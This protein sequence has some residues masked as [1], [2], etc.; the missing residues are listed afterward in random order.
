MV[1]QEVGTWQNENNKYSLSSTELKNHITTM[2]GF[3]ISHNL[4]KYSAEVNNSELF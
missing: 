2:S 1:K 3:I 4:V